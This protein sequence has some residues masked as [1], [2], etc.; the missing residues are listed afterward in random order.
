VNSFFHET[1][2][3]TLYMKVQVYSNFNKNKL[4]KNE[5]SKLHEGWKISPF[6][7]VGASFKKWE[8]CTPI[9]PKCQA[10]LHNAK[11]KGKK[12]P[13]LPKKGGQP[14]VF[15]TAGLGQR[16][17]AH[18]YPKLAPPKF[19]LLPPAYVFLLMWSTLGA[20]ARLA[21]TSLQTPITFDP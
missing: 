2:I 15:Q 13:I 10:H 4:E 5:I 19:F 14:T 9:L 20:H 12:N 18:G 6:Q 8:C 3:P 16:A 21:Q 17:I 11:K 7:D 1:K